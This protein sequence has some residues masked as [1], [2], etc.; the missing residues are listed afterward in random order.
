MYPKY[1]V[2]LLKCINYIL[3]I[4][5]HRPLGGGCSAELK[6]SVGVVLMVAFFSTVELSLMTFKGWGCVY[7][8]ELFSRLSDMFEDLCAWI[9]WPL[10]NSE[11]R[12]KYPMHSWGTASVAKKEQM[13]QSQ[14][15]RPPER[16]SSSRASICRGRNRGAKVDW[17]MSKIVWS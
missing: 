8:H 3:H 15:H 9:V 2:F 17:H 5:H 1:H 6:H 10:L 11:K 4:F 13:V 16:P 12:A 7:V 14:T